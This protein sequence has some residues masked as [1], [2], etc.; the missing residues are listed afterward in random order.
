MSVLRAIKNLFVVSLKPNELEERFRI[1][2][3]SHDKTQITIVMIVTLSIVLGFLVLDITLFQYKEVNPSWIP[4]R[5]FASVVSL[6]AIGIIRHQTSPKLVDH[7]TFVWGLVIIFHMF[8]FN[9]TRP[10]DYI[11]VIVWDILVLNGIYFVV[12]FSTLYKILTAF[13]LTGSSISFWVTSRLHLA[14]PYETVA[15]IA[16][17][18]VSNVYGIF[19]SVRHDRSLRQN[20]VL[21]VEEIKSRSELSDR[22]RELE[23]T[24]EDLRLLAVT[25]PLTGISN[26]RHFMDQLSEE[27][28]RIR[29]YS[30]PFSLMV[31]DIDN[32]K[33][34][35]DTFGHETGDK[36]LRTFAE[37]CLTRLRA[38]DQFARLGGDEFIALLVQTGQEKAKEVAARLIA[39]IEGLE[40]QAEKESIHFTVSIGLTTTDDFSS[41]EELIKRADKALYEAKNGGRNQVAIK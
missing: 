16:A 39:G 18:L 11:P 7:V 23:K 29:R 34:I 19:V 31:I 8:I 30:Y 22:T 9:L 4:S 37:H 40:I 5:I 26:R 6:I 38:V 12:P 10:H 28:K 15:V 13:L 1:E 36:V 14:Y 24:Q 27:F 41:V 32:L 17:Y 20:Y 25:D 21:L 3:L 2:T 35:N 33:E